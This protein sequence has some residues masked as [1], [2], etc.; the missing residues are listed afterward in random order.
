MPFNSGLGKTRVFFLGDFREERN[1]ALNDEI[2][3]ENGVLLCMFGGGTTHDRTRLVAE[4]NK[5]M[6]MTVWS[7]FHP[8]SNSTN[9]L[10]SN[11]PNNDLVEHCAIPFSRFSNRTHTVTVFV[12]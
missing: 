9:T 3:S 5:L 7:V 2:G 6:M 1:S 8:N 4:Y 12:D 11:R 10:K